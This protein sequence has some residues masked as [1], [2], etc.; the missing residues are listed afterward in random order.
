MPFCSSTR[1]LLSP[2]SLWGLWCGGAW[3]W[4]WAPGLC[5]QPI[6]I[7]FAWGKR[8]AERGLA[9]SYEVRPC[10]VGGFPGPW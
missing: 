6:F 5:E 2:P 7:N 9:R 10:L 1:T 4:E 8:E 3:G